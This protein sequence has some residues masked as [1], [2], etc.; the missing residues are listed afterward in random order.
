MTIN[1]SAGDFVIPNQTYYS[2]LKK[3]TITPL[4]KQSLENLGKLLEEPCEVLSTGSVF[5]ALLGSLSFIRLK[6]VNTRNSVYHNGQGAGVFFASDDDLNSAFEVSTS[7]LTD[8]EILTVKNDSGS[9]ITKGMVVRQSGFDATLQVPEVILANATTEVNAVVLGVAQEDIEIDGTG[10][11]LLE[12]SFE[13]DTSSF[14]QN[15]SVY[16]SDTPGMLSLTAGTISSIVGRVLEVGTTGSISFFSYLGGPGGGGG[17]GGAGF[18]TDAAGTDSAVGKGAT[19]PTVAG[20]NS[21]AHGDDVVLGVDIDNSFAMGA[22]IDITALGGSVSSFFVQGTDITSTGYNANFIQGKFIDIDE[23]GTA[24]F[25]Q[26]SIFDIGEIGYANLIQGGDTFDIYLEGGN[27]NLIQGT[28]HSI[29]ES[30]ESPVNYCFIQGNDHSV[31]YGVYSSLVQGDDNSMSDYVTN[32]FAQGEDN[33]VEV[34]GGFAQGRDNVVSGAYGFAQGRECRIDGARGFAQGHY[35][36]AARDDQKSW[37]SNRSDGSGRAQCSKIIK[38]IS[39]SDATQTTLLTF[40][41]ENDRAYSLHINVVGRSETVGTENVSFVLDQAIA[42]NDDGTLVLTGS[43][44]SLTKAESSAVTWGV[45]LAS[46]GTDL[47]LRV[48]GAAANTIHW[49]CSFEF[50]EIYASD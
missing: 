8:R 46:S 17:G 30:G 39:T 19:A 43:P 6:P 23:E 18:F 14:V 4:L 15:G 34:S 37:G 48:T 22:E 21:I 2:T 12:G 33:A 42:Y 27:A 1:Y 38:Y 9:I 36:N 28:S 7:Y 32:A 41:T 25:V 13:A 47:L 11:L 31:G 29:G 50:V 20:E 44:I 40:N 45:D 16:L 49:C 3:Q 5:H 26:G 35:A 10:S 24:N